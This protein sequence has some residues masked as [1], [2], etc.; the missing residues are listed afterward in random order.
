[1]LQPRQRLRFLTEPRQHTRRP[2][3]LGVQHLAREVAVQV[4]IP[5][6][7]HFGEAATTDE[8][9]DLVLGAERVG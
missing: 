4:P 1:M 8:A 3:D 7:V 2:R 6:L 9:L 5:Q